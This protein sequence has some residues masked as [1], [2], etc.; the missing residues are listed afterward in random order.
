MD[1]VIVGGGIIGVSTAYHLS[2]RKEA[3]KSVTIIERHA[4]AGCASGKSGG[5]LARNWFARMQV[6][7]A[8]FSRTL[9]HRCNHGP[10]KELAQ[11]SFAMH[12]ELASQ[13]GV[14]A[15]EYRALDTFQVGLD[16]FLRAVF[17]STVLI[18]PW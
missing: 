8:S 14:D 5:F 11:K 9:A 10:L 15:I 16:S 13:F 17:S 18:M 2:L 4:I 6:V 12:A 7:V 1:I 3:Y